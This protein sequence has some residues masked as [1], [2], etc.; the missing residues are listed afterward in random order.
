MAKIKIV[1]VITRLIKGGAQKVC[2][3]ITEGLPKDRYEVSLLSGPE[4][5]LEGSLWDKA[6]QIQ[7]INIKTVPELVREIS[8]IKDLLALF[9]LYY[10][11]SKIS[12]DIVHC[13]T[14]KAGFIGCLAGWLARVPVIIFSPHGH[15]FSP[16]AKIPSVSHGTL[17]MQFFYFLTK[18]AYLLSTK[19]IAQNS[20]D[21]DEQIKLRLGPARKYEIIHN[22][23]EIKPVAPAQSGNKNYPILATV[24]RLSAEKGQ[25]YLLEALKS[26]RKEFPDTQLLVIGDGILRKELE[27]F[28]EKENL[29]SN[30]RFTGLCD[31]PSQLLKDIDIFVLPSLYESFGIV[32]LEAMA[33]YKPVIAS[34]VNGIPEV[35]TDGE[36]GILVPP[37]NPEALSEAIIKLTRDKE[38]AKKMGIAGYERVNKLFRR[39]QMVDRFDN[40]YRKLCYPISVITMNPTGLPLLRSMAQYGRTIFRQESNISSYAIKTVNREVYNAKTVAQYEENPSIFEPA[41]Q[42]GIKN[43]ITFIS[44]KISAGTPSHQNPWCG[45]KFLDIGCG[46]GNVLKIARHHFGL[47]IGVDIAEK[48]LRQVKKLHPELDLIAA[49]SNRLPFKNNAFNCISLY[50]ALHHLFDPARTLGRIS[51]LLKPNGYLYTDHDPNYFFNRFYHLYYRLKHRSPGF[52][53]RQEELAEFHNTQTGGINPESLK[54]RLLNSGFQDIQVHYRHTTNPSLPML[55]RLGLALLKASSRLIPLKSFHTHFYIIGKR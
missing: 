37:A 10:F 36:T 8:P 22:A 55:E 54:K 38:L 21:R 1:Q 9:R 30:V 50:G 29:N 7:G 5:G 40:L 15:L 4:T 13:H 44:A 25:V 49:D 6:K 34:N 42:A 3:D 33:Q 18:L 11:F 16:T 47:A 17:R 14:S 31:D 52:G 20:A 46:T 28:V 51:P 39:E 2:L 41:R 23:V 32:L 27:T 12:P 53:S 45:G 26:V 35:V 43:I 19:V 48:F 24:G